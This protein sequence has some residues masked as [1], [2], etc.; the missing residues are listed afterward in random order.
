MKSTKSEK[1]QKTMSVEE[2][3]LETHHLVLPSDTNAIGTIF[4]GII[5]SWIDITA[6]ICAG[7]FARKDVVTA[8]IDVLHFL[9]PARL[10]DVVHLKAKIIHTGRTSMVVRVDAIAESQ[11]TR[12]ARRCVTADLSFVA[13]DAKSRPTPITQILP[14]SRQEKLEFAEA[15]ARRKDLLKQREE[16]KARN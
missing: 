2:T 12:D 4:G 5:M 15:A 7:R 1:M 6:A 8:S 11:K 3:I 10:G 14:R 13:L 9:A 16:L